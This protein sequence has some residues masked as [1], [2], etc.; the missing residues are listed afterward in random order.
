MSIP[1]QFDEHETPRMTQGVRVLL[2]INVAGL[3][4]QWTLVSAADAFAVLGFQDQSLQKT[5]WSAL[6]Y[7]FVHPGFPLLALN[8]YGLVLF[9]PRLEAAMGTRA[10]TLYYLW[11]GLGG[12]MFHLLFVRSGILVGASAAVFGV[13][14]AYWQ[15]WPRDE[16]AI[17]G[18]M[19]IRAWTLVLLLLVANLVLGLLGAA[20]PATGGD[21][22]TYLA[23]MGGL[24]FGWLYFHTPPATSL[25]RLRQ[26]ISPAPDYPEETPPR[27]IPRT[28][29]RARA[30]R[31]E[32]DEIVA[33]S[34]AVAAQ[35]R[36][37]ARA[38]ITPVRSSREAR[39]AELDRVLDK[40][41]STGLDSLSNDER[42]VL[43]EMAR[44]LRGEG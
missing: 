40:I 10:F 30:Q 41:S 23:H 33:K 42:A 4:L 37:V 9:G 43:D 18:V 3:F 22:L 35:K 28:L 2:A 32:V 11:C 44:R 25:D 1:L 38:T 8:M 16:V 14:F 31:D 17:L 36:P 26:R 13:M 21:R 24:A 5:L 15:Q 39:A 20:D 12:A 7:M 29:P 19:P 27:A 6:T 34:K